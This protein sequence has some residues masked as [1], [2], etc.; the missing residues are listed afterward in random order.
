M[1][2]TFILVL[3]RELVEVE[4]I[5]EN[6]VPSSRV[7]D[8]LDSQVISSNFHF[9]IVKSYISIFYDEV[10]ILIKKVEKHA[11]NEEAFQFEPMVVLATFNMVMRSTLGIDPKAQEGT[12]NVVLQATD[13]AMEVS[14]D[15]LVV[16]YSCHVML[17]HYFEW[18][19]HHYKI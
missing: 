4:S 11:D 1:Q 6:T 9:S 16:A 8:I 17:R 19:I 3:Q 10:S 12:K 14:N 5:G 2:Y 15:V 7:L 18:A 13:R